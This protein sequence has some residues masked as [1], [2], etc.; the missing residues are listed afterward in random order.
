[1]S[2][3]GAWQGGRVQLE[4]SNMCI[5]FSMAIIA[6][7][8]FTWAAIVETQYK[9]IQPWAEIQVESNWGWQCDGQNNMKETIVRHPAIHQESQM[10]GGNP[11][12]NTSALI[13]QSHWRGEGIGAPAPD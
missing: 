2:A 4:Q 5:A 6:T 1:M 13:P 3:M 12:H 7:R 8:R 11:M 9:I 10:A